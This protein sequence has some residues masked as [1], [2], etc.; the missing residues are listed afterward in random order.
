MHVQNLEDAKY[1]ESDIMFGNTLILNVLH[2]LCVR[3][4]VYFAHSKMLFSV[5][6]MRLTVIMHSPLLSKRTQYTADKWPRI[7][8][9]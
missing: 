4:H 1:N 2:V 8:R 6:P 7:L 3:M 5:F 9:C